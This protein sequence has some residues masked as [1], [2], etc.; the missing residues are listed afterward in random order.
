[1]PMVGRGELADKAW[2]RI[3]PLLPPNGGGRRWCDHRQVINAKLRAGAPW[4]DV[5]DRCGPWKT[6]HER[7][8]RWTMDGTWQQILD[9]AVVK[10]HAVG[11]VEWV[12]SVDSAVVRAHQHRGPGKRGLR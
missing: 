4:R 11:E 9:E 5:P 1:V 6:A 3:A 8:R 12:L 7:L 10:N 2:E